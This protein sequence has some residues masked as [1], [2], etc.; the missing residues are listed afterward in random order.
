MVLEKMQEF[1]Y[2]LKIAKERIAV[3]IGKKGE[4]KN[5]LESLTK[6]KIQIQKQ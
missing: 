4:V 6:T 5:Q 1:A 2:D 3:L